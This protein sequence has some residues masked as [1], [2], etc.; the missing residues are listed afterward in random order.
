MTNPESTGIRKQN[1]LYFLGHNAV[2]LTQPALCTHTFHIPGFNQMRTE[3]ISKKSYTVADV[4][5]LGR[6]N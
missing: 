1:Q 4:C 6:H 3:N 2:I 5:C